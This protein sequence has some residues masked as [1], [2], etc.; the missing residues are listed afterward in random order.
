MVNRLQITTRVSLL[1][2]QHS[3]PGAYYAG[4]AILPRRF[5]NGSRLLKGG[6]K[7]S[8]RYGLLIAALCL[9]LAFALSHTNVSTAQPYQVRPG[10]SLFGIA[11]KYGSS[12]TVLRQ[13][14]HLTGDTIH[15]GQV[16]RIPESSSS[17]TARIPY[18]EPDI[19]LLARLVMSEARGEPFEGQVAA[20]AVT[21]NRVLDSRF[22]NTL[23]DV[24]YQ[25]EG[26]R[27]QYEPVMNGMIYRPANATARQAAIEALYGADPSGGAIG[28]YNPDKV[29]PGN[30]V[31]QWPIVSRIGNHVFFKY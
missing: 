30:W 7:L 24:V 20:A 27:Y 18:T 2:S 15:P 1:F 21:I 22:P 5:L 23:Y 11:Q 19:D 13:V 28:F 4:S 12:V 6:P 16:L 10:D 9:A 3:R 8:R 26:N 14:N 31:W 25:I 17:P 29:R